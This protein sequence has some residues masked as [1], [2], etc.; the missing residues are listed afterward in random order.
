MFTDFQVSEKLQ[1]GI[2][3]TIGYTIITSYPQKVNCYWGYN[4]YY[5]QAVGFDI[6]L[7][8]FI[9]DN[10]LEIILLLIA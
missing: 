5:Y 8:V 7:S 6:T 3:Y 9:S 1:Q 4:N 2:D 10:F